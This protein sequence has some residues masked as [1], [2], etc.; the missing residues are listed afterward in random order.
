MPKEVKAYPQHVKDTMDPDVAAAH[1]TYHWDE[2]SPHVEAHS[3]CTTARPEGMTKPEGAKAT[4]VP[5][6]YT[7]TGD[8][9]TGEM[10]KKYAMQ[11]TIDGR[12]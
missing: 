8:T 10:V 4:K 9:F 6:K 11:N 7:G 2:V 12:E 5:E 1:S 3:Y